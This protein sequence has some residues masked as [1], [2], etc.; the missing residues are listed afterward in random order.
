MRL[1]KSGAVELIEKKNGT[2][3]GFFTF[4][5]IPKLNISG[6]VSGGENNELSLKQN[7]KALQSTL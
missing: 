4:Y 7:C 2:G 1:S 3:G 6:N 5:S